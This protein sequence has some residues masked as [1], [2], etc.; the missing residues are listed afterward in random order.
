MV[1]FDGGASIRGQEA[2]LTH[3]KNA[4]RS[5]ELWLGVG[6]QLACSY[7]VPDEIEVHDLHLIREGKGA[8]DLDADGTYDLRLQHG[9]DAAGT[10]EIWYE[11][12]WQE[13]EEQA[14]GENMYERKLKDGT[15][16]EFDLEQGKWI[17]DEADPG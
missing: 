9:D 12:K 10:R 4:T 16:V 7:S 8:F 1:D 13:V 15:R 14:S 17:D 6:F 5:L 3:H 11:E 2:D